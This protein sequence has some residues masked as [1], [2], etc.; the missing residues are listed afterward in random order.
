MLKDCL[1][2]ACDVTNP[3]CGV[4]GCVYVF[5]AQKGVKE[6]EKESM[7]RASSPSGMSGKNLPAKAE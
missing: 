4:E 6:E 3:L 7:D 5:G 2:D 1:S